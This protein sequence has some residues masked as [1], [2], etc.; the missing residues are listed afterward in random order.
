MNNKI[1]FG[2]IALIVVV[3]FMLVSNKKSS[4]TVPQTQTTEQNP[5][6]TEPTI[7]TQDEE[8]TQEAAVT[9]TSSGF[10]P[11]TVNI[12]VGTK[13][14]WTNKSGDAATV[15][16]NLHPTHL[17]YTPL[18]LNNVSVDGSVSLVFDKPGTYQYHD[19]LNPSR[20]G[21]VEVK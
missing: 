21:T 3:G 15:N 7:T 1:L 12:D 2:V 14:V 10:E 4:E 5:Y 13:V 6:V 11:A 17:V 8:Q 20:T 9:I 18:N 19:H 16:S